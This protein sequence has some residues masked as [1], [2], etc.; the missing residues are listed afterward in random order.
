L[1]NS[2]MP[3]LQPGRAASIDGRI[4]ETLSNIIVSSLQIAL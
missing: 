2:C 3:A 4:E 1:H